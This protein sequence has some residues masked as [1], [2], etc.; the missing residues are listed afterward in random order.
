MTAMQILKRI[1]QRERI[2]DEQTDE[3]QI[4][5][6]MVKL[7]I[8]DALTIED[9]ILEFDVYNTDMCHQEVIDELDHEIIGMDYNIMFPTDEAR[10]RLD[11]ICKQLNRLPFVEGHYDDDSI[12]V[13]LDDDEDYVEVFLYCVINADYEFTENDLEFFEIDEYIDRNASYVRCCYR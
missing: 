1:E 3:N 8:E 11:K 13:A 4:K 10:Q 9:E 12:N 5:M 6:M 7:D 2:I